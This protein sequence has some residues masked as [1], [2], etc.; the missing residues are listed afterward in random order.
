MN[1]QYNDAVEIRQQLLLKLLPLLKAVPNNGHS[2][3]KG[4]EVTKRQKVGQLKR[5]AAAAAQAAS[6]V[7]A[8]ASRAAMQQPP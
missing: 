1:N 7:V 3:G 6:P 8:A 5:R 2:E 4:E